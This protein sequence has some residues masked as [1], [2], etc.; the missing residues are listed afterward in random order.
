MMLSDPHER[1]LFMVGANASALMTIGKN[2][3]VRPATD[4]ADRCRH[5]PEGAA[6]RFVIAQ[7]S[8]AM[9]GWCV[10]EFCPDTCRTEHTV[11]A[12]CREGN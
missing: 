3:P 6:A 7:A 4:R 5:E 12:V 8:E 9:C 10:A 2:N 11:P 1:G